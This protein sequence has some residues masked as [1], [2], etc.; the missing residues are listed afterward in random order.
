MKIRFVLL[1]AVPLAELSTLDV[2][3]DWRAFVTGER[4]W[5]LQTYLR[6]RAAGLDVELTDRLPASGIAVFSSKQRRALRAAN[7]GPTGATLIGVREDVGA[8]LFADYEVVQNRHQADGK[9]SFFVPFWPQPGLMPRD[10]KRGTAIANVGFKG[11][12][13]N[14]H[15]DLVRKPWLDALDRL[16]VRWIPDAIDYSGPA[17]SGEALDWN[18]YRTLDLIV[19]MRPHDR[20]RYPRKPATKLYNAWLAGVPA[21]L[22]PEVAYRELKRSELDYIEI[23]TADEASATIARLKEKPELYAAMVRN[24]A[25][26]ALEFNVA[27]TTRAWSTLLTEIV[28]AQDKAASASATS[29]WWRRRA[30]VTKEATRRVANLARLRKS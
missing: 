26:R 20:E 17:T 3:R 13:A 22:G 30:L 9:R 25:E 29:N 23:A 21:L 1:D 10:P 19:A 12:R 2:D 24:G 11:F 15:S 8:A 7:G 18:D 5:I 14:L 4:A 27:Q 6:L 28:P 16:Q